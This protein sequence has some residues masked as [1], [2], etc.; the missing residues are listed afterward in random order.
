VLNTTR[1][2]RYIND[3]YD[4]FQPKAIN[5]D[6]GCD[7][8]LNNN[9]LAATAFNRSNSETNLKEYNNT[10][11]SDL[12]TSSLKSFNELSLSQLTDDDQI[13]SSILSINKSTK[14]L[15]SIPTF[16]NSDLTSSQLIE[17]TNYLK[18][19]L[20]S[21]IHP[22][23]E[24]IK[25]IRNSFI[26]SYGNWKCKPTSILSNAAMKEWNSIVWKV[27]DILRFLFPGLPTLDGNQ[28]DGIFEPDEESLERLDN[29]FYLLI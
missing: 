17:L 20:S 5:Y 2:Y 14:E 24:L 18:E 3:L 10:L 7:N 25:N 16:I 19:S 27:Y 11:I 22:F 28:S 23:S 12:D 21:D 15:N 26:L 9:S 13:N 6:Y 1:K 29:I 4:N 8:S